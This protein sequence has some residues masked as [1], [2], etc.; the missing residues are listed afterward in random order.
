MNLNDLFQDLALGEL[1][2]MAMSENGTIIPD[3]RI[4]ITNYANEG[5]LA[6]CSRF[7]LIERTMLIEMREAKTNY[8]LLRRYAMSQ[9]SE[10]NPPDR[11]DLPYIFDSVGEPFEEDVIKIL[12]VYNSF[13]QRIPLND[14]NDPLSVFSPQSTVLQVP[15]PIPAQA[16]TL[17]YQAKHRKLDHCD[18]DMEIEL[19]EVLH[20][21]LKAYIASKAYMH[22][23]TQEMTA[24][25]QEHSL[26]YEAI[27][28][29]VVEKDLVNTSSQ[30]TNTKFAK[31]GFC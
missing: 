10:D 9:Y 8:H 4:N 19:P 24:K 6:L 23:N 5:M 17:E 12:S 13:G 15:Y 14:L 2:N 16:L 22:M 29:E 31:R 7:I 18:C 20:R 21:A 26:T 25:G 28:L 3:K 1:S 30:T 27:C 11:F